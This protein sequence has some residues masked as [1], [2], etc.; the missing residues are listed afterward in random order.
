MIVRSKPIT[1]TCL[2]QQSQPRFPTG[3]CVQ[4]GEVASKVFCPMPFTMELWSRHNALYHRISL[5]NY[6]I[7]P[8]RVLEVL[9][10][11][12]FKFHRSL[13]SPS[14]SPVCPVNIV[15]P[16]LQNK[17]WKPIDVTNSSSYPTIS[18]SGAQV[19]ITSKLAPFFAPFGTVT[20]RL[21]ILG[22]RFWGT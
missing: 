20:S 21:L 19:A 22:L 5:L 4:I 12:N 11:W 3:Q 13:I 17:N 1:I 16:E 8:P 9:A 14:P 2:S 6:T 18:G 15:I 7:T 10:A